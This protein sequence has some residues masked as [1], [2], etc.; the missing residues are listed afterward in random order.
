LEWTLQCQRALPHGSFNRSILNLFFCAI[1]IVRCSRPINLQR[2]Q[3]L[4]KLWLTG[5][6]A[7]ASHRGSGGSAR[8]TTTLSCV[9]SVNSCSTHP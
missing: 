2:Q 9:S 4:F 7:L 3:L 6:S 8:T 1:Q 5:P